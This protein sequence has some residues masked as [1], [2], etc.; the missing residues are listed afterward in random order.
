VKTLFRIVWG[1]LS[2]LFFVGCIMLYLLSNILPQ[3]WITPVLALLY[4]V[5]DVIYLDVVP[6]HISLGV[7]LLLI[8]SL[9][10]FSC[11]TIL[12]WLLVA[13][14]GSVSKRS[15]RL[16]AVILSF[17]VLLVM[18]NFIVQRILYSPEPS[19]TFALIGLLEPSSLATAAGVS[20]RLAIG[21]RWQLKQQ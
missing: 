2:L 17:W 12:G 1:L 14:Y 21:Y 10:V 15:I 11:A 6:E 5:S 16:V 8:L 7:C 4:G 9:C 18:V 20:V 19:F 3:D 13:F